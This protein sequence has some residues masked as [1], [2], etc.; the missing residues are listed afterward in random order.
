LQ[1]AVRFSLHPYG[2][3]HPPTGRSWAI[4]SCLVG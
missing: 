4:I 3:L 2:H 1:Q